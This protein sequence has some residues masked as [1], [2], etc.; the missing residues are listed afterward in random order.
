MK[1]TPC[2]T[3][4]ALLLW[5]QSCGLWLKDMGSEMVWG[6]VVRDKIQTCLVLTV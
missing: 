5:K 2:K 1:D 3:S 4:Q 6:T